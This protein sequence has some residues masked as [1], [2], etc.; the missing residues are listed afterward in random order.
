MKYNIEP[1]N[2]IWVATRDDLEDNELNNQ[3]IRC[4]VCISDLDQTDAKSPAKQIAWEKFFTLKTHYQIIKKFEFEFYKWC[5][6]TGYKLIGDGEEAETELWEKYISLFL[7]DSKECERVS[8]MFTEE[9]IQKLLYPGI[10][11]FYSELPDMSKFYI[12]RNIREVTKIF[13]DYLGFIDTMNVHGESDKKTRTERFL[14]EHP[15]FKRY[16]V[17]GDR[18]EDKE[19]L[20]VL[21]HYRDNVKS[22]PIEYVLG[23]HISDAPEKGDPYFNIQMGRNYLGLVEILKKN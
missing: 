1:H 5:L 13:A 6:E 18:E 23:C 19:I 14:T 10:K 11:E 17:K 15:Q 2:G 21:R 7:Q 9:F 20:K 22:S 4:D 16:L 3:L 8:Q 12:T